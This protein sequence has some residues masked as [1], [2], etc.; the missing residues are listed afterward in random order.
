MVGGRAK[1]Q[2]LG[3]SFGGVCWVVRRLRGRLSLGSRVGES[4]KGRDSRLLLE[5]ELDLSEGEVYVV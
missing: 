4:R 5:V 2:L 1:I 3:R